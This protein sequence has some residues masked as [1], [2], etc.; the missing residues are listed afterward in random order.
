MASRRGL[1]PTEAFLKIFA[2]DK[3][4]KSTSQRHK[5]LVAVD[6]AEAENCTNRRPSGR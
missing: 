4:V 6:V 5:K 1:A 2:E 3:A